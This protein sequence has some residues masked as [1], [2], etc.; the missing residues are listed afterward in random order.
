MLAKPRFAVTPLVRRSA[1]VALVLLGTTRSAHPQALEGVVYLETYAGEESYP[2]SPEIDRLRLGGMNAAAFGANP[3]TTIPALGRDGAFAEVTSVGIGS[4]Y[5]SESAVTFVPIDPLTALGV[6]F[7]A[8]GRFQNFLVT[9]DGASE[10]HTT[11]GISA[12]SG[13]WISAILWDDFGGFSR[14]LMIAEGASGIRVQQ[15]FLPIAVQGL[16]YDL[17]LVLDPTGTGTARAR[18][19][20]AETTFETPVLELSAFQAPS[21]LGQSLAAFN[22]LGDYDYTAGDTASVE[23][24]SLCVSSLRAA[25]ACRGLGGIS[26]RRRGGAAELDASVKLGGW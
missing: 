4:A 8:V 12:L 3:T 6:P 11:V 18:L 7:A 5:P 1:L 14:R 24:R 16:P 26:R 22:N 10:A 23:F 20:I 19:D 2:T 17:T 13:Y 15:I 21:Y 9:P 25:R